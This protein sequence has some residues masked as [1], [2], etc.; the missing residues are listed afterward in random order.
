MAALLTMALSMLTVMVP[1]YATALGLGAE[2]IG[3][4]IAL[5]GVFPVLLGFQAGR[6]VDLVG[7]PRMLF[8]SMT[9]MSAA[10][11]SLILLP[12][13][14]ALVVSRLMVG[15]VQLFVTLASQSL[16][17]D[18]NNN[19]SHAYN[20]A[21]YSTLLALGRMIGPV[22]VGFI[23][24]HYGFRPSFWAVLVVLILSIAVSYFVMLGARSSKTEAGGAA[25]VVTRVPVRKVFGNVGFQ[26]G[27]L[28][29][30][31]IFLALTMREAF[32]PVML[33]EMGMSA[34]LI[35]SLVSLGSLTAV[36]I[37]PLL[38]LVNRLLRGTARSLVV[39]MASVVVGVGLLSVAS[40]VPFFGVL[41]VIAGFGSGLGFPL[42]I[43]SVTT[44]V[45]PRE[46]ATA[47]SLRL[48]SSHLVEMIA[49]VAGGLLVAATN[50]RVGFAAA[51]IV[52]AALTLVGVGRIKP[53]EA[54]ER[55]GP[56]LGGPVAQ[57]VRPQPPR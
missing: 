26:M 20:F 50:Y 33:E 18:L 24:D 7:P 4:L 27:V 13:V 34:T 52:L 21:A 43:V 31:G 3:I 25:D 14:L 19:R 57:Q 42:S 6:W 1:L 30:S 51:G 49:P 23:I 56:P 22:F 15:F 46:R 8:T 37:R 53:F 29:S 17:A 39:S 11:L 35:G 9:F 44:H 10:P 36:L 48:T 2:S 55:A 16:I 32:L 40:S 45:T 38:P 47:L 12:G 54:E 28:A 41:A 5:P